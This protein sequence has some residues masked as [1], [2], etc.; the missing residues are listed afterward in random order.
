[1]N[2]QQILNKSKNILKKTQWNIKMLK[3]RKKEK[4][5]FRGINTIE[6]H[7]T[8][9]E[10][11]FSISPISVAKSTLAVIIILIS[12]YFIYSISSLVILFFISLFFSATLDP[13]V[14]FFERF[15]IPRWVWV[16]ILYFL[17]ITFLIL[18]FGSMIPIIVQQISK[19]ATNISY[20]ILWFI[21]DFQAGKIIVPYVWE[22]INLWVLQAT[23]SINIENIAKDVIANF[24]DFTKSLQDLAK[25]WLVAVW[26]AV[27]AWASFAWAIW[28]FLMNLVLVLFMTFFMIIDRWNLTSF[29]RS[30][31]PSKYWN[32]IENKLENIQKQ[33][34]S[35][36]R[37]QMALMVIMFLISLIWLIIIWMW[38]YALTLA[39]IVWVWEFLPYI[40]PIAFLLISLPIALNISLFTIIKLLILYAI[41]QFVEWNILVPSVMEKAVWLSPIVIILVILIWFQFL[42]V[43]WAIISVPVA[44]AISIFINDYIDFQAKNS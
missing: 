8:D 14:D 31:F 36:V 1:M 12:C 37:W 24:S 33:I 23:Q 40:W 21:N 5:V 39:L 28:W 25:W 32:Y 27:W 34:G 44:T 2:F 13:A 6:L 17:I 4:E 19:I 26:G 11:T 22:K 18:L 29:F 30:L 16:V 41:L 3:E 20:A 15:K 43:I 38:E 42:G 35:W 7:E 10:K 9:D